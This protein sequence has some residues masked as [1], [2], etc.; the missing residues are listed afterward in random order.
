MLIDRVLF[1]RIEYLVSA[2]D[3]AIARDILAA[4]TS[5]GHG[6][7]GGEVWTAGME[8]AMCRVGHSL[9]NEREEDFS[10]KDKAGPAYIERKAMADE[11][12][13]FLE[14]LGQD[15]PLLTR[16]LVELRASDR[17]IGEMIPRLAGAVIIADSIRESRRMLAAALL[18]Q[19]KAYPIAAPTEAEF[20]EAVRRIYWDFLEASIVGELFLEGSRGPKEPPHGDWDLMDCRKD[21]EAVLE[22]AFVAY[23]QAAFRAK[24]RDD[25]RSAAKRRIVPWV[26][27]VDLWAEAYAI[28]WLD[29]NGV[30]AVCAEAR[31]EV[32][33]EV[34]VGTI[35]AEW[36]KMRALASRLFAKFRS[37]G[38][39]SDLLEFARTNQVVAPLCRALRDDQRQAKMTADIIFDPGVC[40]QPNEAIAKIRAATAR[41]LA[42]L[43]KYEK[44][45]N[46]LS[47]KLLA[48]VWEFS[49]W[50]NP[51]LP[52]CPWTE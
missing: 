49:Q 39:G 36:V 7:G 13:D 8:F 9:T 20:V 40:A 42:T 24:P 15:V 10:P 51:D 25:K 50:F 31:V 1:G 45:R 47:R 18:C 4:V 38:V 46:I 34:E 52:S 48:D 3:C 16:Y 33:V 29:G 21:R 43:D 6:S 26:A 5:G 37:I 19:A 41:A 23:F 30:G 32:Q 12:V 27:V 17:C 14:L 35:G 2:L 28:T 11:K 22:A 44:V